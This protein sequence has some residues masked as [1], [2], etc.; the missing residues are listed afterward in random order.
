MTGILVYSQKGLSRDE[1][2][3]PARFS[4]PVAF[5]HE[6]HVE[7]VHWTMKIPVLK[8]SLTSIL[9]LYPTA[10]SIHPFVTCVLSSSPTLSNVS[11]NRS[12]ST[13]Y[14]ERSNV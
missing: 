8:G 6:L 10:I 3:V 4:T 5:N 7:F 14:Q 13:S 11:G 12:R 9:T 2:V 1:K